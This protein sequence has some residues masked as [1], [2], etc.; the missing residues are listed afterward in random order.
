MGRSGARSP[1]RALGGP[2]G[3]A[4][5]VGFEP[6]VPAQGTTV[7]ETARFGH[8]RIPPSLRLTGGPA[9]CEERGEQGPAAGCLHA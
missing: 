2:E 3:H 5:G 1:L 7:F 6:T 9:G 4:E 8:S